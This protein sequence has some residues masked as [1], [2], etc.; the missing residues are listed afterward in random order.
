METNIKKHV[1]VCLTESLCCAAG[2]TQPYKP[3]ILQLNKQA[4]PTKALSPYTGVSDFVRLL[5]SLHYTER[6]D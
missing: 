1:Y 2:I 4:N 3:T 5:L 6:L